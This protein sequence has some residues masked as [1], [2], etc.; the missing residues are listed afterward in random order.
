V[1]AST[2]EVASWLP[3]H[4]ITALLVKFVPTTFMVTELEPAAIVCGRTALMLGPDSGSTTFEPH[5][6]NEKH[7]VIPRVATIAFNLF[8]THL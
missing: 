8:K 1:V 4:R 6:S 2:T 7:A 5:P 3:F